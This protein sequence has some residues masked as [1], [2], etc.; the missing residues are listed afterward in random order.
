MSEEQG[1]QAAR[2]GRLE[3]DIRRIRLTASLGLLVG[4]V[5]ALS[6]WVGRGEQVVQADVVE[7]LGAKGGRQA[8]LSADTSG[9]V[10]TLLDENGRPSS[11]LRLTPEPWLAV[12]TGRGREV[13]RLGYPKVRHLKE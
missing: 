8:T 12:E 9:F 4:V 13:A 6:A 10:L 11:L 1:A 7:L 3:R 2:I 5:V